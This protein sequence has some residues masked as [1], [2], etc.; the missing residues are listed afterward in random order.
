MLARNKQQVFSSTGNTANFTNGGCDTNQL[1]NVNSLLADW[2]SSNS[3]NRF[4]IYTGAV[5]EEGPAIGPDNQTSIAQQMNNGSLTIER[6]T[7]AGLWKY[8]L[9]GLWNQPFASQAQICD[10]NGMSHE[11]VLRNFAYTVQNPP[12]G[13]PVASDGQQP[14]AWNP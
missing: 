1:Y 5:T 12:N 3:E 8:Y 6:F 7:F 13:C 10:Y 2:L 4:V 14:V 9:A 11:D